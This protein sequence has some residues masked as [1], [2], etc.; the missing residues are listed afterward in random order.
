METERKYDFCF[1]LGG[2]CAGALQ[3]SLRNLR[4]AASPFDW[5]RPRDGVRYVETVATL[6]E[7]R[8]QGW[9]ALENLVPMPED[10]DYPKSDDP[11][12]RLHRKLF[13][14]CKKVLAKANVQRTQ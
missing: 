9:C 3:L 5:V 6:L 10:L 13:L 7:N 12:Y 8:F 1:S 4:I 11:H 14:H 2:S